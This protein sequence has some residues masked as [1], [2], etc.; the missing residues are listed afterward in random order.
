MW[1]CTFVLPAICFCGYFF[2]S[3][4]VV[5]QN[6]G[7]IIYAIIGISAAAVASIIVK[8]LRVHGDRETRQCRE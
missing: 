2:G 6:F 7:L 5:Q 3:I 8:V 4:P 1:I